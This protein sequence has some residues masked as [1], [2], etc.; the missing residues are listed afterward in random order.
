MRVPSAA[1]RGGGGRGGLST[2]AARAKCMAERRG[3]SRGLRLRVTGLGKQRS[4]LADAIARWL[5]PAIT[6]DSPRCPEG[7][8]GLVGDCVTTGR[9][10]VAE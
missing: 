4:G 10:C 7:L 6:R 3:V 8:S 9:H 1:R 5:R 2:A